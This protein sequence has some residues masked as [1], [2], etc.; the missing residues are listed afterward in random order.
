[1]KEP[2]DSITAT[3]KLSVQEED[4]VDVSLGN[5]E[6]VFFLND[7]GQYHWGLAATA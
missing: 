2:H 5:V 1:M 6:Q 4:Q 7:Q 3:V